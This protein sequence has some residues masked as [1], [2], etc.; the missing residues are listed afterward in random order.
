MNPDQK[1]FLALVLRIQNSGSGAFLT[2]GPG[3]G[4]RNRFFPDPKIHI[5]ESLVTNFCVKSILFEKWP[6]FFL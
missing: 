2:Y 6:N 3:S 5:F 1:E 4:I